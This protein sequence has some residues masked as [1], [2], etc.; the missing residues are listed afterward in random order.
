MSNNQQIFNLRTSDLVLDRTINPTKS[1]KLKNAKPSNIVEA[2]GLIPDFFAEA[3]LEWVDR[4]SD[5]TLEAIADNMDQI[6]GFGGFAYP[7][8]GTVSDEG[9]YISKHEED[10]P[11]PPLARYVFE[12]NTPI[13]ECFVYEYAITAIRDTSTGKTKV[14]RFD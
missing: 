2:C 4:D 9:M 5:L 13:F 12:G 8:D 14:A 6:Y 3:C 11:L 10:D 1:D 7:Y